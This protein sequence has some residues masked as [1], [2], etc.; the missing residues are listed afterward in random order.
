LARF[1]DTARTTSRSGASAATGVGTAVGIAVGVD[2]FEDATG[3][4]GTA[5]AEVLQ[6]STNRKATSKNPLRAY[7]TSSL[8]PLFMGNLLYYYYFQ[9]P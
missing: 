3:D 8:G 6:A 2:T 5:V 9:N 7:L 1:L 4:V